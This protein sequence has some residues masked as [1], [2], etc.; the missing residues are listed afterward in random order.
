MLK[1]W[2]Q[3]LSEIGFTTNGIDNATLNS[4]FSG[5]A[6]SSEVKPELLLIEPYEFHLIEI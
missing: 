3:S 6:G 1:K 4:I 2:L 5:A